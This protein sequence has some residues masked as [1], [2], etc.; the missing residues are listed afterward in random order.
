MKP[1]KLILIILFLMVEAFWSSRLDLAY[2]IENKSRVI[3][4]YW[5]SDSGS[6]TFIAVS[7]SSLSTIATQIGLVV[8][9]IQSDLTAFGT[10]VT[11]TISGGSTERIFIVRTNSTIN[12]TSISSAQ[13]VVGT[14]NFKHGHI[15]IEPVATDPSAAVG[16][17]NGRRDVTML[18]FWG[19]VIVETNTTGFAM[20]FIGDMHD[21]A[22]TPSMDDSAPVSGVN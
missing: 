8:N 6:Y 21:S 9:V 12:S 1:P 3:S 2:A 13:F 17:N 7:H 16:I 5:Q 14:T 20:E 19:A 4:P 15:L 11:F 18:N 22:A 10:A